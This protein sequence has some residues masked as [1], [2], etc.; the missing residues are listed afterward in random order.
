MMRKYVVHMIVIYVLY[1]S[2]L[3]ILEHL[4]NSLH[5]FLF[6]KLPQ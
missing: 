3:G 6:F 2:F 1:V 5:L 4:T